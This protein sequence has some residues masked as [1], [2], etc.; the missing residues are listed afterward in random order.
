[1]AG[2]VLT[3]PMDFN[4]KLKIPLDKEKNDIM[5]DGKIVVQ[6]GQLQLPNWHMALS[7]VKGIF[8][9]H[10]HDLNATRV[11]AR[12]YGMPLS[13]DLTTVNASAMRSLL[14][15]SMLGQWDAALLQQQ[16]HLPFL[17]YFQGTTRY[18]ALLQLPGEDSTKDNHLNIFSD[19]RGL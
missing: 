5:S 19:L 18:R 1:M 13:I 4:L 12:W 10:N 11:S 7:N 8:N 9:F 16:F 6:Q 2:M 17:K 15:I 3:V 14:Q